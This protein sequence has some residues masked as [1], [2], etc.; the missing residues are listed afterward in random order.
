MKRYTILTCLIC[1][2]AFGG[3][4]SPARAANHALLIG[5]GD[6]PYIEEMYRLQGPFFD[7]IALK[8]LLKNSWGFEEESIRTLSEKVATRDNILKA[9]HDLGD[10]TQPGDNI[11]IFFSGHGTSSY[12]PRSKSLGLD[13][14][15]GALV[16]YDFQ[17]GSAEEM[18]QRL[19]I[20]KRDL[21]P[22]LEEM[23]KGR[24]IF[25]VFDTCYAGYTVRS[26]PGV[27]QVRPLK[28]RNLPVTWE[29]LVGDSPGEYGAHTAKE[30]TF[31]YQNVVY[32]SASSARET[33]VDITKEDIEAGTETIDGQPHGSL[34]DALLKGLGGSA[35][36]NNDRFITPKE[37]HAYVRS[38]VKERFMHTPRLYFPKTRSLLLDRPIFDREIVRHA[39][40]P[41]GLLAPE[42]TLRVKLEGLPKSLSDRITLIE[43]IDIVERNEDIT[44]SVD[45]DRFWF[46][47]RNGYFLHT[48]PIRDPGSVVERIR[49]QIK[50]KALVGLTYPEQ[51]F[52]IFLDLIHP[53]GLLEEGDTLGFKIFSEKRGFLLIMNIDPTGAINVIYPVKPTELSRIES[54][55][56]IYFSK[57]GI[58]NPPF[59][60]EYI[61]VFV[62]ERKPKGLQ[63]IMAESFSPLDASFD[64]LMSLVK[65]PG[66]GIAQM[67]LEVET[68]PRIGIQKLGNPQAF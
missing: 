32:L 41:T 38:D 46:H 65:D 49:R 19:I 55:K 20:G 40:V 56:E 31:P 2:L 35:D 54:G 6:Y 30:P 23:E 66:T 64:E 15:T 33:A 67:T 68:S 57:L 1:A 60:T 3:L 48:I 63:G 26:V 9:F 42:R 11:F 45:Q 21:R 44:L 28:T 43:G 7:V 18:M 53:D 14:Y 58:V 4:L 51:D 27:K 29:D 5:V 39:S 52:N 50:I 47:L 17:E 37:L 8:A 16:P 36:T 25:V 22:L 12:D 24:N 13:P 62:F 59:G 10:A 34:T 61:K